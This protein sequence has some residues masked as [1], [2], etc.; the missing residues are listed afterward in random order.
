[1]SRPIDRRGFL[2]GSGAALGY[3]FTADAFSA[4]RAADGPNEILHFAGIGIGGKGD[5]DITEAGNLGE[6]VAICDIDQNELNKKAKEFPKAR[7][8]FDYRKMLDEMG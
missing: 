2:V 3:F 1:M 8:Y 5:S 4:V 6:V 7:Q